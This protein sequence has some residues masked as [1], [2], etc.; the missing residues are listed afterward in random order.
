MSMLIR[1][2][3]DW[4]TDQPQALNTVAIMLIRPIWDWN[5]EQSLFLLFPSYMLIRPIWDWNDKPVVLFT[6][7]TIYVNQTNLG[8][9]YFKPYACRIFSY[10][11]NQTNLGLK[12]SSIINTM[13]FTNF[14]LIRPIWDWN[15]FTPPLKK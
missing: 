10:Y 8:L 9:K 1:P 4:N 3:W 6:T 12:F 5:E 7:Y 13:R 2:I 15:L 11:V 14:M